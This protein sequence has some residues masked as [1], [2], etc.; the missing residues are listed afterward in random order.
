[1]IY[2]TIAILENNERAFVQDLL[3]NINN[4]EDD[5]KMLSG[6]N[7]AVITKRLIDRYKINFAE[8][9]YQ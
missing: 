8:F 3:L 4:E 6:E 7:V 5:N 2:K 1:M 9:M